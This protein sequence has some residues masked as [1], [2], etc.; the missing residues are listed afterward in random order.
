MVRSI[1]TILLS[2]FGCE[3]VKA[4]SGYDEPTRMGF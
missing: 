1:Y 3:P 2:T 4:I